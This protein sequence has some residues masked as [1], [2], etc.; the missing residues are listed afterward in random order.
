LQASATIK[1]GN[2]SAGS[3]NLPPF[4]TYKTTANYGEN[5]SAQPITGITKQTSA[6]AS[7]FN[8]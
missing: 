5:A 1:A 4:D 3:I 7:I 6:N 8:E 2:C